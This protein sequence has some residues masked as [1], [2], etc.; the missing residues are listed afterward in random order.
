M[1][2]LRH[3]LALALSAALGLGAIAVRAQEQKPA[4]DS[5]A[6]RAPARGEQVESL[7]ALLRAPELDPKQLSTALARF[8]EAQGD[9]G[10][11]GELSRLLQDP[12]ALKG[13][14]AALPDAQ[15]DA[16][17]EYLQALEA[18]APAPP[19][20]AGGRRVA[21][22][23]DIRA[24]VVTPGELRD[25]V[26]FKKTTE[27]IALRGAALK[28]PPLDEAVSGAAK[29]RPAPAEYR[30]PKPRV[31]P[32]NGAP[33]P[34]PPPPAA[35]AQAPKTAT[36]QKSPQGAEPA[37]ATKKEEANPEAPKVKKE[38]E[39]ALKELTDRIKAPQGVAK[40]AKEKAAELLRHMLGEADP[41][42]LERL[43]AAK[44]DIVIIPKG[45]KMTELPEFAHL[46]GK[47]TF[48][49]RPWEEVRGAGHVETRDGRV[50]VAVGEENLTGPASGERQG[51][52]WDRY[53][54]GFT[55]AHEFAHAVHK[56][57][58][59]ANGSVS[60]AQLRRIYESSMKRAEKTG[61]GEYADSNAQEMWAQ[62]A[63]AYFGIK[64]DPN[65][66]EDQVKKLYNANLELYTQL[67][68][69][70]GPPK[71]LKP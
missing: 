50:A 45:K 52:G 13:L 8:L 53:N 6:Q 66:K 64:Y 38:N 43:N 46:A 28:S 27:L 15:R 21:G 47:K 39:K 71:R 17:V 7:N 65:D 33:P 31:S 34:P 42:V 18:Q 16:L 36:A 24:G 26:N 57:G 22:G 29:P 54:K 23:G 56:Y 62:G 32:E 30:Q 14:L 49:G 9:L 41:K 58:L 4:P 60:D 37:K 40:E 35:A 67:Y 55:F 70:Y 1:Q 44:V 5:A 68:H 48:D 61:L 20:A 51:K 12:Q 19:G 69:T 2:R 59:P 10:K 63:S 25:A 3:I 11:L